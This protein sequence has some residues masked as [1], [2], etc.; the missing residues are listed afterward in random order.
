MRD[1]QPGR[2]RWIEG[3][4]LARRIAIGGLAA[5]HALGALGAPFAARLHLHQP[6]ATRHQDFH[7]M[8][9]ACKYFSASVL[10]LAIVVGP[11]ARGERWASWALLVVTFAMFGG[12]FVADA[13]TGGAPTIDHVAYGAFLAIS[14]IALAV[15][16]VTRVRAPRDVAAS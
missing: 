12:V 4:M 6:G 16:E 8:W 11:L 14:L 13:I 5:V 7:V 1:A 9:E 15:L 3:T 2:G 10:A